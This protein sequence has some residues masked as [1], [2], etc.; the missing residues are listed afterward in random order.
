MGRLKSSALV[1]AAL[2]ILPSAGALAADIPNIPPPPLHFGHQWYLR[3][4]IGITSQH[5]GSL[6]NALYDDAGIASVTNLS[7]DF[8]SSPLIGFGVGIQHSDHLRFDVTGEYRSG[9]DFHGVDSVTTTVPDTYD[10]VYTGVKKEATFLA[11]AYWDLG[12]WRGFTPFVG[13]GAG[14]SYNWITNFTDV[15]VTNASVAYGATHGKL[16]FA[17]ALHAGAS[18]QISDRLKLEGS[19][20]YIDLGSAASGDLIAFDGTN[21]IDNPMEFRHLTSHDI[22]VGLRWD[23]DAPSQSYYPPVVKY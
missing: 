21:T 14:V 19:Y 9:A 6:Y 20:R 10:D 16:N 3:G 2:V 7:K 15:S 18:Y 23:L 12:T 4:D 8:S 13:V 11:N 22:R 17:W 5:V 1:G